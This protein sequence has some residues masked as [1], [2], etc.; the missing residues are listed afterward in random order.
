MGDHHDGRASDV[1]FFDQFDDGVTVFGVQVASRFIRQYNRGVPDKGP[2]RG[3]ALFFAAGK[4]GRDLIQTVR[5]AHLAQG[6]L[7]QFATFLQ[8]TAGVEQA[9]GDIIE[10]GQAAQQ[11]KGLEHKADMVGPQRG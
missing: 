5:H 4:L 7:R 1:E 3:D 10:R 9:L 2:G 6:D 11:V 8:G